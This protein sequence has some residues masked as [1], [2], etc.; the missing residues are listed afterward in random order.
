[1]S[2]LTTKLIGNSKWFKESVG[3]Q[4]LVDMLA[5]FED[6]SGRAICTFGYCAGPGQDV[7]LFQGVE[8]GTIVDPRGDGAFGWDPVFQPEGYTQ[9]YAE[10]DPV[11]KNKIS[12]RSKAL[13]KLKLFLKD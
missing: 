3:N 13:D 7:Q 12:H 9:T 1:M 5:K 10:M 8:P 4:G 2:K 11:E 6:K